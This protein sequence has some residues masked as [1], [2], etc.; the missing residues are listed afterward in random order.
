MTSRSGRSPLQPASSSSPAPAGTLGPA[1]DDA[2]SADADAER[3]EEGHEKLQS[4][5]WELRV[6]LGGAGDGPRGGTVPRPAVSLRPR[7]GQEATPSR[8][9]RIEI[10]RW[11]PDDDAA[12]AGAATDASSSSSSSTLTLPL[13]R[14]RGPRLMRAAGLLG[15][16]ARLRALAT[17]AAAAVASPR[18]DDPGSDASDDEGLDLDDEG[19]SHARDASGTGDHG[20]ETLASP[21]PAPR[22]LASA[23]AALSGGDA[24]ATVADLPGSMPPPPTLEL[25]RSVAGGPRRSDGQDGNDHDSA[26][27]P[28]PVVWETSV[29]ADDSELNSAF[30]FTS[31]GRGPFA[32]GVVVNVSSG[33]GVVVGRAVIPPSLLLGTGGALA[34]LPPDAVHRH[35]P[36]DVSTAMALLC[37]G[38]PPPPA[39]S[40]PGVRTAYAYLAEHCWGHAD[41]LRLEGEV[42]APLISTT[43]SALGLVT[44][45]FA[46]T[47]P[48]SAPLGAVPSAMAAPAVRDYWRQT[49]V[50]GHRGAGADNAAEVLGPAGTRRWRTHVLE[51]TVLSFVTAASLGAEY[52]EFDVQLSSDGVPVVHHDFTVKLPG[53]VRVPVSHLTADQLRRIAPIAGKPRPPAPADTAAAPGPPAA[54]PAPADPAA[55]PHRRASSGSRGAAVPVVSAS[56]SPDLASLDAAPSRGRAS[57][58]ASERILKA[59]GLDPLQHRDRSSLYH[60]LKD[61]L[62]TLADAFGRVPTSCGFNIE[63]KYPSPQEACEEHLLVPDRNT[64]VDRVLDCVLANAGTR[65]VI[66]SS[67]DPDVCLLLNRKQSTYPVLLLTNAG[68]EFD[69]DPRRNSLREAIRFARSVG[70]FGIV[71]NSSP[72]LET[73]VLMDAVRGAGLVLATFGKRNNEIACV[74]LQKQHGVAAIIVDHVAHISRG[75]RGKT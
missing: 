9:M 40:R 35:R 13:R 3:V 66:F 46:L 23:G 62:T 50:V 49:R 44:V 29:P 32:L 56:S 36:D 72:L 21:A 31:R 6:M 65:G 73:P 25:P 47:R 19:R 4:D 63:M 17:P 28:E 48:Y 18:A 67:F 14:R 61:K 1:A 64:Y 34:R 71:S 41:G 69:A 2:G 43:G 53:G 57:A 8:R 24:S 68:M 20:A 58:R 42:S 74:E 38:R 7:R 11:S 39:P 70:L 33:V 51:N 15:S 60:G 75:L 10:A 54:A 5:E 55:R 27:D 26:S 37:D 12:A 22:G 30:T 52:V 16:S 45:R 59:L